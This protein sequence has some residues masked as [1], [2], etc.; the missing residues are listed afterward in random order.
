MI[1]CMLTIHDNNL[2]RIVDRIYNLITMDEYKKFL[3]DL[4]LI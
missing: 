2:P 4:I 1:N 3:S